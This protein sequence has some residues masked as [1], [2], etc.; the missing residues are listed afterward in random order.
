[1]TERGSSIRGRGAGG[2]CGNS[3]TLSFKD[4][5]ALVIVQH[6]WNVIVWLI[7]VKRKCVL[8]CIHY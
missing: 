3:E 7:G 4:K 1:M 5:A 2:V 6:M 8:S